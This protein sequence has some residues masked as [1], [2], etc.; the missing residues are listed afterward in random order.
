MQHYSRTADN[1]DVVHPGVILR[2]VLSEWK[3]TQKDLSDAIGKSTPV[4][5]DIIMK[6]RSISPEIA[7][8]LEAVIDDIPATEWLSYQSQYDL[9]MIRKNEIVAQKRKNLEAWNQLKSFFNASYLKKKLCLTGTPEDNI[10]KI[11]QFF[12]V[13]S[14]EA[15][16]EKSNY[17]ESYFRRSTS[18]SIDS[19]NLMTW[20]LMVRKNSSDQ[21]SL[22]TQFDKKQVDDLIKKLNEIFFRNEK[23]LE[24]TE[25]TLNRY[26]VKFVFEENLE[27]TPVDGYSFWDG[28]NPTIAISLRYKRLDNF[29]FA[30]MHE[31]GHIV[32][33]M[34]RDKG[35]EFIDIIKHDTDESKEAEANQFATEALCSNAPL[36]DLFKQWQK[37]PFLAKNNI[38]STAEKYKINP[39]IITGQFQYFCG[40]YSA[41]R[42]LLSTVDIGKC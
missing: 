24:K 14:I 11:Y 33:H 16:K 10:E 9:A 7:Y 38:I 35:Q 30:I 41:C 15:L 6:R 17:T 23:T 20:M 13:T 42:D 36:N 12:N 3:M 21:P 29:A 27:R 32:K 26:G 25:R 34:R 31:L 40:T 22:K 19:T 39:S 4:I 5:N 8:M 18:L 28:E 2:Q 1:N 37:N